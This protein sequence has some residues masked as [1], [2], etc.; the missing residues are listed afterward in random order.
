MAEH[1]AVGEAV[2]AKEVAAEALVE[3]MVVEVAS[4]AELMVEIYNGLCMLD[5]K[6]EYKD[7]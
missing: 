5:D 3:Q 2:V 7:Q 4:T 6:P 1:K